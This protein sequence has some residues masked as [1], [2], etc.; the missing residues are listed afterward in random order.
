[1]HERGFVRGGVGSC[2][3]GDVEQV[4]EQTIKKSKKKKYIF[5]K[6]F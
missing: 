5:L 6:Q 2:S 4:E 3:V 1:M